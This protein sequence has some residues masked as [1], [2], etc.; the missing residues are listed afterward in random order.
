MVIPSFTG[1]G[2]AIAL[3]TAKSCAYEFDRRQKGFK[4]QRSPLLQTLIQGREVHDT[5]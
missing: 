5:F 3:S 2:M 1:D 4:V